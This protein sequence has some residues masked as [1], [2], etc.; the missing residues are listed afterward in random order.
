MKFFLNN[1]NI[2]SSIDKSVTARGLIPGPVSGL[3][4]APVSDMY[5][6]NIS[7]SREYFLALFGIPLPAPPTDVLFSSADGIG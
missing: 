3:V 7:S 2:E 5:L 1:R 4:P 6:L